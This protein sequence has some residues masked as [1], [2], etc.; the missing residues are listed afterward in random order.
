[1]PS[2]IC[3]MTEP[4]DT[5]ADGVLDPEFYGDKV[6]ERSAQPDAELSDDFSLYLWRHA[7][8]DWSVRVFDVED[9]QG[10]PTDEPAPRIVRVRDAP[11]PG[12]TTF[13]T[14]TKSRFVDVDGRTAPNMNGV[15][16]PIHDEYS[17]IVQRDFEA[18]GLAALKFMLTSLYAAGASI[19]QG[20]SGGPVFTNE[21]LGTSVNASHMIVVENIYG[22]GHQPMR[23]R[24][25]EMLQLLP[26]TPDEEQYA[27]D[28]GY[29]G[30]I[31]ALNGRLFD[32]ADLQ[33]ESIVRK[34]PRGTWEATVEL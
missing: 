14:L 20:T 11:S 3:T 13:A 32:P 15:E 22:F 26:I 10:V 5:A 4:D 30:I 2:T 6:A 23:D 8:G 21:A 9:I 7:W 33:R 24:V 31:G 34:G 28:H 18:Q 27:A 16:V 1:M 25:L 19:P 29:S 17:L 12:L